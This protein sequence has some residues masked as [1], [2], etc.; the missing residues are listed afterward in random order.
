M[1]I[2]D[3]ENEFVIFELFDYEKPFPDHDRKII[4]VT[5]NQEICQ[6]YCIPDADFEDE[7]WRD[8]SLWEDS[9]TEKTF[10][11]DQ[12]ERWKYAENEEKIK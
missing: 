10:R 8:A 2:I 6:G 1:I 12:V 11:T 7:R 9:K 3:P 5:E 4:F